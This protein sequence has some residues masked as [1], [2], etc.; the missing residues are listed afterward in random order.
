VYVKL[1]YTGPAIKP[2][3]LYNNSAGFPTKTPSL[4]AGIIYN[5]LPKFFNIAKGRN[6]KW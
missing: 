6:Q 5:S 3:F 1:K 4:I 2:S